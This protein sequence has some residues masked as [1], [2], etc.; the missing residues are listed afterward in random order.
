M[1][2]EVVYTAY[3]LAMQDLAKKFQVALKD[4]LAFPYPFA[5]GY[6]KQRQPFGIRDMKVKT[7]SLYNSINV[8]YNQPS[9][10]IVVSMLDYWQ[11][12]NDGR[13][14]GKYVPIKPLMS[15][16]RAKGMNKNKKSGKF[17]KFKIKG[18]AFA[19]SKNIQKFGIAPTYF[20]D[21]AFEVFELEF[22]SEAIKAL[23]IDVETFFDRVV[24]ENLVKATKK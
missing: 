24:E 10:E 14:P 11:F 9:N 23:G 20:Y 1:A 6:K 22:E 18:V 2:E 16:I 13:K 12:V 17:E 19:I 15:W 8:V 3:E 21:K 4:A 5:P 7:G